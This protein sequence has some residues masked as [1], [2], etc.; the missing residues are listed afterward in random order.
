MCIN[1]MVEIQK[2]MNM[3]LSSA[4]PAAVGVPTHKVLKL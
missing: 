4:L 3:S 1:K 2:Y